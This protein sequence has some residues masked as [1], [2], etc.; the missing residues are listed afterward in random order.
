ME[1]EPAME[2]PIARVRGL[3]PARQGAEHWWGERATSIAALVLYAWLLV[4]LLR[5]GR[6]DYATVR[7]WL[8]DPWA[9]VPM[10]LLVIVTFRHLRDGLQ[11]SIDDYVHDEGNRFFLILLLN[12][13]AA[14]GAALSLFSVLRIAF[15]AGAAVTGAP[16]H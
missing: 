4:S 6:L 8:A 2:T 16:G 13:A 14:S 1:T 12:F 11:V 9:A 15:A 3:G 7:E 10:I 5:L